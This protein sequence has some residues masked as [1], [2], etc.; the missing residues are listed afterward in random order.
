MIDQETDKVIARD[1]LVG[2]TPCFDTLMPCL[3]LAPHCRVLARF[4]AQVAPS[5][6]HMGVSE[7]RPV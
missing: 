2:F 4:S 5:D 1:D 7:T 6:N 3:I